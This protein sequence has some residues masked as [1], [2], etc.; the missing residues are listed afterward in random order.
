MTMDDQE[1]ASLRQ[2]FATHSQQTPEPAACPA[3]EKIWDAVQGLLPPGEVREIVQHTAV[4]AACAEDWR[5]ARTM[6]EQE[7]AAAVAPAPLRFAPRQHRLRNF[8][9]AAAAALALAVVGV[10]WLEKPG[11]PAAD[12]AEYREGQQAAIHSRVAEGRALPR[13][14]FVLEWTAP[15]S[16]TSATSA[17]AATYG[18]EVSTED[19][20]VVASAEGLHAPQY[21]VP[22]SALRDLP[23]GA[24]LLW[25]VEAEIPEGGHVSSPTFVTPV[26]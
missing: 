26:Q 17:T 1:L 22:A 16:A 19:L 24:R 20:R 8:G 10:Q 11:G 25:K 4:C 6:Q 23:A 21:Q 7:A 12:P 15:T 3:P 18:V 13:E 2:A 5:L 14:R 9:L